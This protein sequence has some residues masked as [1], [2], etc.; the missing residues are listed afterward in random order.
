MY[1][2]IEKLKGSQLVWDFQYYFGVRR[3]TSAGTNS[4]VQDA[5]ASTKCNSSIATTI[6]S[7]NICDKKSEKDF[8]NFENRHLQNGIISNGNGDYGSSDHCNEVEFNNKSEGVATAIVTGHWKSN[9]YMNNVK[10]RLPRSRNQHNGTSN[11]EL[12]T[13]GTSDSDSAS[14]SVISCSSDYIITRPF[15]YYL[16]SFGAALGDEAFYSSFFPFWFWNIDGAVCRRVVMIWVVIMYIGQ[17]LKDVVR[18]PRPTSPPVIRLEEKWALEYGMP[19]THA[20]VGAAVPFSFLLYTMFRYEVSHFFIRFIR[21]FI[22]QLY[23]QVSNRNRH[24]KNTVSS[25]HSR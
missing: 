20:M 2:Y 19:S 5:N 4:R 24:L 3:T 16:F 22:K 10:E 6:H 18:W 17:G 23:F 7:S 8:G 1:D 21:S 11:D 12:S 25:P 13:G 15:W 14:G 9:G